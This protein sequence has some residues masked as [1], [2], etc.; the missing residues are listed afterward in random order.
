MYIHVDYTLSMSSSVYG[1]MYV[2]TAAAL[3]SRS[4][5]SDS[6]SYLHK[7]EVNFQQLPSRLRKQRN[8]RSD[9]IDS[10]PKGRQPPPIPP[11]PCLTTQTVLDGVLQHQLAVRQQQKQKAAYSGRP[12]SRLDGILK[13]C[14]CR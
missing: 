11:K 10:T 2:F 3:G 13:V 1:S 4:S 7:R 9:A 5:S 8:M 12:Q 6:S 14:T